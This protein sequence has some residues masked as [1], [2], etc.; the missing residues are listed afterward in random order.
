MIETGG[1]E[2]GDMQ[3]TVAEVASAHTETGDIQTGV[4]HSGGGHNSPM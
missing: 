2:S 1:T 4:T 3:I